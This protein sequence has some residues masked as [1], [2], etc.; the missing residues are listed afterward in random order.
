MINDGKIYIVIT[1]K[2]PNGNGAGGVNAD[3]SQKDQAEEITNHWARDRLI[4]ETKS[5]IKK[6]TMYQLSNIGNFTGDYITQTHVND[7]ISNVSS[8]ANIGFSMLAGAKI[9]GGIGAVVGLSLAV[10][11]QTAT[12]I[13]R[14]H[15]VRIQNQK[16]NYEI[17][18]LRNRA[19]LN[20][21]LDGSRGTEN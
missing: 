3:N 6:A 11:N 21:R 2:L 15:S 8:L 9:A 12:D 18:Q 17:E 13:M 20:S 1:D 7:T 5:L 4:G 14:I 19:G 16:T 10:I